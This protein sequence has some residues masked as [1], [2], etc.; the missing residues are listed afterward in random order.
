M[1]V[2]LVTKAVYYYS[3][4]LTSC[5]SGHKNGCVPKCVVLPLSNSQSTDYNIMTDASGVQTNLTQV[6]QVKD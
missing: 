3:K 4:I 6:S 5:R 1:N 2:V